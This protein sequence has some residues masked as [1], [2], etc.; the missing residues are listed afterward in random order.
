[1]SKPIL[2]IDDAEFTRELRHADRFE[3]KS[4]P[5]SVHLGAE[6]LA[7]NLTVVAPGKSA[8]PFHNH[9]ANEELF[10]ILEGAGTLRFG[11]AEHPVRKGDLIACP[12]GGTEMAHQLTNTGESELRYLALSTTV[13]T[14]IVQYPESGKFAVVAG[15]RPGMQMTDAPFAGIYREAERRDYWED[16]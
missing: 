5:L 9:H 2:N 10:F 11:D 8:F 12:P 14:D 1:M 4:A 15:Y 7:Y 13:A 6:K 3:A 16:E